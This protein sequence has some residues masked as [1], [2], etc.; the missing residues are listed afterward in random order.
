MFSDRVR[1]FTASGPVPNPLRSP[2]PGSPSVAWSSFYDGPGG[3]NEF[4]PIM[5]VDSGGYS[6][7]AAVSYN[8]FDRYGDKDIAV[9][10]YDPAGTRL[11]VKRFDDPGHGQDDACTAANGGSTPARPVR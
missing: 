10:K 4:N 11:W 8:Q 7:V 2:T 5:A 3:F 6:Y 9:M 1:D